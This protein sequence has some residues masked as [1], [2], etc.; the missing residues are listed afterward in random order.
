MYDWF[1]SVWLQN[2]ANGDCVVGTSGKRVKHRACVFPLLG[3]DM[4]TWFYQSR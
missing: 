1:S 3:D 2:T 4:Q